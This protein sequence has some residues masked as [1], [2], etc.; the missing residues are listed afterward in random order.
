MQ[1]VMLALGRKYLQIIRG[2][3]ELVA[4]P[5]MHN[6]AREEPPSDAFFRDPAMNQFVGI[7]KT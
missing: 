2:I 7:G 3:I 6:L 4:I 1:G 5:M